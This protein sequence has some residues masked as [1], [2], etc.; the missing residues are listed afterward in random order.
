LIFNTQTLLG[1]TIMNMNKSLL[2]LAMILGALSSQNSMAAPILCGDGFGGTANDS[3]TQTRD[4]W[5]GL[6]AEGCFQQ[7]KLYKDFVFG[8]SSLPGSN[9]RGQIFFEEIGLQDAHTVNWTMG[10]PSTGLDFS[11]SY[12]VSVFNNPTAYISEIRQGATV[13]TPGAFISDLITGVGGPYSLQS[14]TNGNPDIEFTSGNPT[15][16][17]VTT[18]FNSLTGSLNNGATIFVEQGVRVPEPE[19]LALFSIGLL[20]LIANVKRRK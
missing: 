14:P 2:A 5:Q 17:A 8:G 1:E 9:F 13:G 18:S 15:T 3:G 10:L 7:D 20:A 4:Y 11:V 16:L 6:S 12:N 19:T